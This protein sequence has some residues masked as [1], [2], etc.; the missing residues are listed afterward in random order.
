MKA[1]FNK[2]DSGKTFTAGADILLKTGATHTFTIT[3]ATEENKPWHLKNFP[4][5]GGNALCLWLDCEPGGRPRIFHDIPVNMSNALNALLASCGQPLLTEKNP[6]MNPTNLEGLQVSCIVG[7]YEGK[8][9]IKNTI[10]QFLPAV[11]GP[12]KVSGKVSGKTD[13]VMNELIKRHE[14]SVVDDQDIPF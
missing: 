8:T 10:T 14:A 2:Q 3:K 5:S 4:S 9:G 11:S 7:Q 1:V 6:D 12:D 13:A